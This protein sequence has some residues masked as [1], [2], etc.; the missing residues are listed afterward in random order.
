MM[1][2]Q[3]RQYPPA[4][5]PKNQSWKLLKINLGYLLFKYKQHFMWNVQKLNFL[6]GVDCGWY[7]YQQSEILTLCIHLCNQCHFDHLHPV[8][9]VSGDTTV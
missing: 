1:M 8:K 2:L 6:S 7:Y 9:E 4:G 3:Y 5:P